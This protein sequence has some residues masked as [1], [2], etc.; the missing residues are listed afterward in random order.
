M[1][2]K[3]KTPR[4]DVLERLLNVFTQE[5]LEKFAERC[6]QVQ[7]GGFGSVDV[8][9]QQ[10]HPRF[11]TAGQREELPKPTHLVPPLTQVR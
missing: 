6:E 7:A 9:F 1:D 10:G 2:G 3:K 5:Q 11:I 8:Q 4:V